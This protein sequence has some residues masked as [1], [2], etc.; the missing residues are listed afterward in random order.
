[1][2]KWSGPIL[3]PVDGLA[4]IGKYA[5]HQYVATGFSGNGMTYAG[6]SALLMTDLISGKKNP[7]TKVY[8]PKRKLTAKQLV[9]KGIDYTSEFFGG[10]VKNLIIHKKEPDKK[11]RF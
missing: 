2:K 10:A 9:K 3:E 8:D 4:L 1:V 5:P 6:I 7:W 11:L